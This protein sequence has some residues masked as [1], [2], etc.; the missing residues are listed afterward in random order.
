MTGAIHQEIRFKASAKR[1]YDA[2]T[3]ASQFSAATGGAPTEISRDAGG[4]FSCF[5]GRVVGRQIELVPLRRV[6]QAWR[7]GNWEEGH[8]S[9]VRIELKS[10]GDGT[11]LVFDQTGF[12]EDQRSH[13]EQGWRAMYW[14]PLQKQLG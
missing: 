4:P 14:E 5:G 13:L 8:Y 3:D 7:A 11:R 12:P 1:V 6:V 9:I 10:E 2:L